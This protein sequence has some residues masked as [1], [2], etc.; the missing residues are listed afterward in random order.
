MTSEHT[1]Q[2]DGS[3]IVRVWWEPSAEQGPRHWRGWAQH[4]RNG[5]QLSFQQ[6]ADLLAFIERE[7]GVAPTPEETAQGLG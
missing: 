2:R 7:T 3:F 4:V 5:N 1:P 6:I